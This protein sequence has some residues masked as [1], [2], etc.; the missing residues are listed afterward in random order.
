MPTDRYTLAHWGSYRAEPGPAGEVAALRPMTDDPAPSA[1]G[2]SMLGAQ[3]DSARIG[4]PMVRAGY[5]EGGPASRAGRGAEPFVPVDWDRATRLVAA[6]LDR[7]RGAHGNRAIF[8]GS[9]GW[10]SAG[11]F[12]HAQSQLHRFLNVAGGY[13]RSV[14]THSHAAAEVVLPHIIGSTDGMGDNHTPWSLIHDACELFVAFGGLPEKNTQV[15]AGG[16]GRHLVPE[17]LDRCRDAGVAFVNI[18]PLKSDIAARVAAEWLP[19]RP[20]SDTALMLALA[21]VLETEGRADHAFLD[22]YTTGFDRFR[23]YLTGAADGIVRDPEWAAPLCG[24]AAEDIRALARRMAGARTMISVAWALQRAD[25]GEQPIWAAVALAAMLGQIGLPGGGFGFGYG[26]SNRV[27]NTDPAMGWPAL[28]QFRNP[29]DSFIPVARLADMLLHPGAPFNYDGR[30]LRYPDIRLVWWAGGNPF[31][32]QQDLNKLIAA[33]RRPETVIVQ[34]SWWTATARHADIVLPCTTTLERNDLGIAKAEPHLVAMHRLCAPFGAARSDY[35][36]LSQI[37]G[38]LGLA[39][40]FTEGR[41]EMG[42]VR[43]LYDGSRTVAAARGV[44]LPDFETFWDR[45]LARF[46][47]E[48]APEPLLAAFRADPGANPLNTPSGRIE[49]FSETVAG[50]GYDDCPGHPAWFPPGEWLG[51][52]S[53]AVGALHLISNQPVTRL[54]GQM[55]N[56]AVSLASKIDGREPAA[57]NPADAAARGIA[58][59]ALVR[60][61]NDRGACLAGAVISD[62]VAPGVVQLATGAWFNPEEPGRIGALDLHGNPNVLTRD[63]G[64]SQLAQGPVAHSALVLAEPVATPQKPVTAF[65]PPPIQPI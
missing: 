16:V 24:V 4:Q 59:G 49:I 15:S 37:A 38:H 11:R 44:E 62:D 60:L 25:H 26:C 56:G 27:G 54:H 64:T 7:I 1:L 45:G 10:A 32:H 30:A 23:A 22:R 36:I 8:G 39:E 52:A 9:Y 43:H 13:S 12:H 57:F 47:A 31:H 61:F 65:D 35:D 41:D 19:V 55:D 48:R 3:R 34:D 58:A 51:A 20:G 14:N 50:F 46:A 17:W 28:P 40:A 42:W 21:F 18:S 53:K 63:L 5:L 2:Q 33:W 29:V 6:E